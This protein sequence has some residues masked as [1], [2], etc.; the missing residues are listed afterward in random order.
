VNAIASTPVEKNQV[1]EMS[2]PKEEVSIQRVDIIA[3]E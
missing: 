2:K 1:G 3:K